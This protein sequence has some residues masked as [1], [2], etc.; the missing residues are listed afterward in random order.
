MNLLVDVADRRDVKLSSR[1]VTNILTIIVLIVAL[2]PLEVWLL[3]N[4]FHFGYS[5]D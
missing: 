2:L 1:A 5:G 3:D 4:I